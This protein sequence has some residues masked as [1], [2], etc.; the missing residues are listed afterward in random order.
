MKKEKKI[1]TVVTFHTT[2]EAMATEQLSQTEGFEGRLIPT[3]R[4]LS[5]GCG[6]AFCA[7]QRAGDSLKELLGKARIEYEGIYEI[8]I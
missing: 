1:Q 5:A 8:N 3:P 2:A 4:R 7:P 6:I